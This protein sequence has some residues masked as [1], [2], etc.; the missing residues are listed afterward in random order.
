MPKMPC[1]KLQVV[2]TDDALLRNH[3]DDR[4][5]HIGQELKDSRRLP[6]QHLPCDRRHRFD[7]SGDRR[8]DLCL[9]PFDQ[10]LVLRKDLVLLDNVA[11]F[12]I[13]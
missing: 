13:K 5:V 4:A 6:Q 11:S 3:F 10:R 7:H 8:A 12:L 2:S 1:T 9:E